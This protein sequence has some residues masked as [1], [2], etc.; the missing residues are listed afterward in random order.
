[1]KKEC[2]Y[3]NHLKHHH[4]QRHYHPVKKHIVCKLNNLFNHFQSKCPF[5]TG[6]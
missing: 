6:S 5:G 2:Q 4:H 1:M 3:R